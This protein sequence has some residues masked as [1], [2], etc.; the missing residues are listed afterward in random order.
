MLLLDAVVRGTQHRQEVHCFA[1]VG[2]VRAWERNRHSAETLTL[3]SSQQ[4]RNVLKEAE[5]VEA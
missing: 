4:K 5:P 1:F 3:A 2:V